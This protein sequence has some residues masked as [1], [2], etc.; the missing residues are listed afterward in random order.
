MSAITLKKISQAKYCK[1]HSCKDGR[2]S[3]WSNNNS[4][5]Y[6]GTRIISGFSPSYTPYKGDTPRGIT[7]V[8][9]CPRKGGCK[10]PINIVDNC[11]NP[12]GFCSK[13]NYIVSNNSALLNKKLKGIKYGEI[14]TVKQYINNNI[15]S[16]YIELKHNS[17]TVCELDNEQLK[18]NLENDKKKNCDVTSII[19][20][21]GRRIQVGNY[22][23]P[24]KLITPTTYEEYLNGL[25]MKN[26]CLKASQSSNLK[27]KVKVK[28]GDEDGYK[29]ESA[30]MKNINSKFRNM[31]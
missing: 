7:Y 8:N 25:L 16:E 6:N 12:S 22:V 20:G 5:S 29:L 27:P 21:N 3:L 14:N 28:N 26:K 4:G 19:I 23:K 2:F 18:L 10:Y 9:K 17:A 1:N 15:Q 30:D 31:C 13:E 24:N 11:P